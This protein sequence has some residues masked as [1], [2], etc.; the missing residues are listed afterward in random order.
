LSDGGFALP[1]IDQPKTVLQDELKFSPSA[2]AACEVEVGLFVERG[3]QPLERIA[4]PGVTGVVQA[5]GR[6][7]R[8]K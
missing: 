2:K 7:R 1:Q 4:E 6:S 3:A 8:G 5:C